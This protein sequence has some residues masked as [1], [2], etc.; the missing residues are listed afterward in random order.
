MADVG[1]SLATADDDRFVRFVWEVLPEEWARPLR[2]RRWVPFEKGGGYGK[3]FGH[4]WW[5]VW[6]C[7]GSVDT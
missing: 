5:V 2:Q 6:T 1:Q 3:W 4:P 7:F